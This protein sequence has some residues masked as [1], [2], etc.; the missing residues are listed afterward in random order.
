MNNLVLEFIKRRF[1]IDCNW[2]NGNC[3]YFALILTQ[4]FP[5]F[6]IYYDFAPGHFVAGNRR[7]NVYYD[8]NGIYTITPKNSIP[9][10]N[11]IKEMDRQWY[12]RLIRDCV[13]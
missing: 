9:S 11:E 10:L 2:T 13:K 5:E 3:Y 8:F 1:P 4:A 7:K 6:E 12:N